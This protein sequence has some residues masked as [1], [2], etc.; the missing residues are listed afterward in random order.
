ML[1]TLADGER[2][3]LSNGGRE[4]TRELSWLE[5]GVFLGCVSLGNLDL[6]F[7]IR[8]LDSAIKVAIQK[9]I[10]TPKNPSSGWISIKKHNSVV[11]FLSF[12]A[13]PLSLRTVFQI[14]S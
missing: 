9:R 5:L 3:K 6:D 13:R 8:I 10:S 14:I 2:G 11:F 1:N 12:C 7:E 4:R